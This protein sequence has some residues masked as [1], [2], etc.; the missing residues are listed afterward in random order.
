MTVTAPLKYTVHLADVNEQ[1]TV[2]VTIVATPDECTTLAKDLDILEVKNFS[3]KVT[4]ALKAAV[5]YR[6]TGHIMADVV[7]ACSVDLSPVDEAID[8]TFD[9]ILT[10]DESTLTPEEEFDATADTP[11]DV[12]KG[13]RIYLHEILKQWLALSLNP[14]PRSDAPVFEYLEE[15]DSAEGK[16]TYTPF[17]FLENLKDK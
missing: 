2:H 1:R 11:V 5:L 17:K 8:E 6:I 14:Y 12:I 16:E 3:A 10:T 4:I 15:A 7:Q 13:D 9:E